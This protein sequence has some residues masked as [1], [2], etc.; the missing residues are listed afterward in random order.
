M[1]LAAERTRLLRRDAEWS[2]AASEGRDVERILSYW[3]MTL[4]SFR[5]VSRAVDICRAPAKWP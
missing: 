3:L 5:P 1:D 4:L 2:V